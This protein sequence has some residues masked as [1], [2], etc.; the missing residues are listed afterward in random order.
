MPEY[1][2]HPLLVTA[3]MG[4]WDVV[5]P[6]HCRHKSEEECVSQTQIVF[7]YRGI[8]VR[9]VGR[10]ETVAD[11]NQILFFNE[12]E[13]YRVSHPQYGGDRCLSVRIGHEVL[14][15]LAPSGLLKPGSR[16][17]FNYPRIRIDAQ[18][19]TRLALLRHNLDRGAIE[20]LEAETTMIALVRRALAP[21][22]SRTKAAGVGRQKLVDRAKLVLSS[23]LGRRWTLA[24]IAGVVGVS[25]VYLTQMFQQMEG[26]PLYRYQLQLRLA[27]ALDLLAL[28]TDLTGL[29][30]D[31]GFSS[32]SHF[33]AAFKRAY[34]R[35]PFRF[36]R[37][38]RPAR[39]P[40]VR[41]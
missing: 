11:A 14:A 36:R 22:T 15:E 31:L 37:S 9:H 16:L 20:T 21:R 18:T 1:D 6:G 8:F 25:P 3:M 30:F 26:L 32:Y 10:T 12:D 33:S 4:I 5:C 24:E 7:P 39:A 38:T 35:T 2:A 19:Q 28:D 17:I 27:R 23:D 13:P 34:G 40:R 29:A 41:T